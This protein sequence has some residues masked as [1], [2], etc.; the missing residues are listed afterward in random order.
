MDTRGSSQILV[1]VHR[2]MWEFIDIR[3][4]FMDMKV[5]GELTDIRG[6]FTNIWGSSQIYGHL[7][8]CLHA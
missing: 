1:G 6:E 8:T 4:D 5:I 2:Y 7:L 3:G